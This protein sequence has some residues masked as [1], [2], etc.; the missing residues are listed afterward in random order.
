MPTEFQKNL[1]FLITQSQL[2]NV[3]FSHAIFGRPDGPRISRML[4]GGDGRED[5]TPRTLD[6]LA[7]FCR[8][9]FVQPS[10]NAEHLRE[11]H[12]RFVMRTQGMIPP[13]CLPIPLSVS[14]NWATQPS[15][16]DRIYAPNNWRGRYVLYYYN[17]AWKAVFGNEFRILDKNVV[18]INN[19]IRFKLDDGPP[20]RTPYDGVLYQIINYSYL[21]AW[22]SQSS[23]ELVLAILDFSSNIERH[24]AIGKLLAV[25]DRDKAKLNPG[26][27]MF[28]SNIHLMPVPRFASKVDEE[29]FLRTQIGKVEPAHLCNKTKKICTP[30]Q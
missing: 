11:E 4:V 15:F 8:S 25:Q 18:P 21:I 27:H 3:E 29:K 5:P 13:D 17:R 1:K 30:F 6:R 19:G 7:K 22:P 12:H 16:Y 23:S 28:G 9:R 2:T 20:E 14:L 10:F 26:Q 24:G